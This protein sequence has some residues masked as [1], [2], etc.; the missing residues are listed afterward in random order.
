MTISWITILICIGAFLIVIRVIHRGY[1]WKARDGKKLTFKQFI[2]RF[3]LGV[4]GIT[5]LQ[6]SKTTL[7]SFVPLF[8]GILWGIAATFFLKTYWMTLILCGSL[9]ITIIQFISN[10]QKYRKQKQI[11][12]TM[13]NLK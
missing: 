6:Q 5:P 7:W 1:F 12:D 8:G 4:E 3:K 2:K 10:W 13:R 9:P 11:E